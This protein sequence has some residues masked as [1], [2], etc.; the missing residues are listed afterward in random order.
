MQYSCVGPYSGSQYKEE[1]A[2]GFFMNFKVDETSS[3][4]Q[5]L[6]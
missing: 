4:N 3:K 6:F 2:R 5:N 1:N